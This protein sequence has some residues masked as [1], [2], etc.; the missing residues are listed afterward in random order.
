MSEFLLCITALFLLTWV[1]YLKVEVRSLAQ[2]LEKLA[3]V[4]RSHLKEKTGDVELSR[5]P[6]VW[7]KKPKWM[8]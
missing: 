5:D 4:V 8:K 6:E 2:K 3:Q 7:G 1:V